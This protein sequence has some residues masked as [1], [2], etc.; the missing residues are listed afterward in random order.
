MRAVALV[1][2]LTACGDSAP[3]IDASVADDAAVDAVDAAAC[4][5]PMAAATCDPM[6]HP[7]PNPSCLDE[8]PGTGGCPAGMVRIA[9]FCMVEEQPIDWDRFHRW[10]GQLRAER[11]ENLLRVKGILNLAGEAAPIAVH[12]VHHVFHPPVQLGD[13]PDDDRRSRI[14]FITRDLPGQMIAESWQ[15]VRG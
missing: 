3:A 13:W 4:T 10:L 15:R 8:P 11:G 1:L 7:L 9:A 2:I 12:G 5:L 6:A 14:V